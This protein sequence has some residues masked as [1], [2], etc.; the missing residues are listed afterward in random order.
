MTSPKGRVVDKKM[1]SHKPAGHLVPIFS[2]AHTGEAANHEN[3]SSDVAE[4]TLALARAAARNGET[5][6]I[7]DFLGGRLMEAAGIVTGTTLTDVLFNGGKMRDAKFISHNEHFTACNAGTAALPEFLGTMAA[8]SM[9]YDWLLAAVPP[10]CTPAHVRLAGAAS[11]S[12]MMFDSERDLFM[13]AYWML[14]AV[15]ARTPLFSPHIL[16]QGGKSAALEAYGMFASTV[17]EFLGAPP[18]LAGHYKCT[19]DLLNL[20]GR[21][22]SQI[23]GAAQLAQK[24]I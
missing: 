24:A 19:D 7:I 12:V 23:S 15:R 5:V 20:A 1:Q 17:R 22:H 18:P 13:R 9:S 21:L 14:D 10:G 2:A 11:K 8:M 6:L 16:V 4:L 3:A